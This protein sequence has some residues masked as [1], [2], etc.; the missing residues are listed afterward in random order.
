MDHGLKVD[1]NAPRPE[2]NE[3]SEQGKMAATLAEGLKTVPPE[4]LKML[5]DSDVQSLSKSQ[6]PADKERLDKVRQILAL[7][8]GRYPEAKKLY[9]IYL[10]AK[11]GGP[12]DEASIQA[13]IQDSAKADAEQKRREQQ[14]NYDKYNLKAQLR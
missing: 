14:I 4:G 6:N 12:S 9:V 2:P 13:A 3:K 11:M 8:P 1:P 10:M 5:L 7:I